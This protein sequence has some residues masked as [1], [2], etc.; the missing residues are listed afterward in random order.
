M[1]CNIAKVC[2]FIFEVSEITSLLGRTNNF[3]RFV[4]RI[5]IFIARIRGFIF[6]VS[7]IKN[8]LI[9]DI[10]LWVLRLILSE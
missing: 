9:S 1:S 8:L 6:E 7:E 10:L 5:V 4:L 3:R 2:S